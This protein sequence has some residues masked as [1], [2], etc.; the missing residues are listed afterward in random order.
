MSCL[1]EN[2]K[3]IKFLKYSKSIIS[4]SIF[5]KNKKIHYSKKK[6]RKL[7]IPCIHFTPKSI[8]SIQNMRLY[9]VML[10]CIQEPP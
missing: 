4:I 7:I 9:Y 6:K 10:P 8:M 1:N 3:C 5:I 2:M